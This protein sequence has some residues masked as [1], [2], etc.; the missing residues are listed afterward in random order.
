[1]QF[2]EASNRWGS[3]P[4]YTVLSYDHYIITI[5]HPIIVFILALQIWRWPLSQHVH[6]LS[7]LFPATGLDKQALTR[8][9]RPPLAK[10]CHNT[11][12]V[13]SLRPLPSLTA[14]RPLRVTFRSHPPIETC[15]VIVFFVWHVLSLLV[16]PISS[17]DCGTFW[18]LESFSLRSEGEWI[19]EED[20]LS[21]GHQ[22]T[23]THEGLC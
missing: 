2:V 7:P 15:Q 22:D 17:L 8:V 3:Q 1:M 23:K 13:V 14:L 9:E 20:V 21:V 4:C 6:N 10:L 5:L 18:I 11:W 16:N 12:F 19:R